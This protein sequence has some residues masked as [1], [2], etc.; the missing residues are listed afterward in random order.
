M[1]E[2]KNTDTENDEETSATSDSGV[3][4]L[5]SPEGVLML[6]IALMFD[7]AIGICGILAET[8]IGWIIGII[9]DAFATIVFGL[10]IFFTGRK[11][12]LKLLLAFALEFIPFV[13]DATPI[14]SLIGM[15]FG[16][17]LPAS[18]IGF[19]YSMLSSDQQ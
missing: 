2:E 4:N 7:T 11:G 18:W 19:A 8:I 10:W 12:W 15:F 6:S 14:I 9:L 17:K 5:T 16:A 13:D 3:G 1:A